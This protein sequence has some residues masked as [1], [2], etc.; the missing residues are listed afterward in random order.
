MKFGENQTFYETLRHNLEEL[1][2]FRMELRCRFHNKT[3]KSNEPHFGPK[4]S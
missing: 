3:R 4:T 1:P 2:T